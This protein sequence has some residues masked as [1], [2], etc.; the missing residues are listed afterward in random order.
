[1]LFRLGS[2][3]LAFVALALSGYFGAYPCSY[4]IGWTIRLADPLIRHQKLTTAA[5]R[6]SGG[7]M[8]DH[9]GGAR[10]F[11]TVARDFLATAVEGNR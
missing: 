10:T 4:G 9:S 2:G 6:C 5:P 11:A 3:F 7:S 8:G 1:M